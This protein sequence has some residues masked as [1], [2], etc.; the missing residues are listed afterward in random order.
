[1]KRK[2]LGICLLAI[3]LVCLV[4]EL[5]PFGTAAVYAHPLAEGGI[6]RV[7][8]LYSYFHYALGG[9][10]FASGSFGPVFVPVFTVLLALFALRY[11]F[12]GRGRAGIV[13]CAALGLSAAVS[14]LFVAWYMGWELFSTATPVTLVLAA[15]LAAEGVIALM[16]E[17]LQ[18]IRKK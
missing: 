13:A 2:V 3:P 15:L 16:I 18:K 4:L 7:R 5:L 9:L 10:G 11:F 17:P 8:E 1:M 14:P 6:E 12:T